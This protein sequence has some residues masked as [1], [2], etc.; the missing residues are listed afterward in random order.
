LRYL[1]GTISLG[2]HYTEYPIV[3]ESYCDVNWISD[4]GEIY[5]TSGYVFSL[6]GRAVSW[7]SCKHTILMRTTMKAELTTLGIVLS[8]VSTQREW[9]NMPPKSMSAE[10][11]LHGCADD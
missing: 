5:D 7:K 10:I 11:H 4:V 2:I 9:E 3:L 1:K 6:G 8:S